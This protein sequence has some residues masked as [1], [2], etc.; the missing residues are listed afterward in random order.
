MAVSVQASG[1]AL[2]AELETRGVAV[3]RGVVTPDAVDDALRHIHLGLARF[4]ATVEE[5][6]DYI[7]NATWFPQLRWDE[8]IVALQEH[9]P[10][11]LRDGE[12]CDPQ[13]VLGF[14][15]EGPEPEI[16]P[17]VDEV[18]P[19]AGGRP[20]RHIAG[21]ALTPAGPREGALHVFPFDADG[22]EVVALE[23]GDVVVM[24]GQ[25]PHSPGPNRRGA[26]R[27]AVYFR[28]LER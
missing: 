1:A 16:V 18:P 7:W 23:P 13:I 9:F 20:Y 14:P 25:L 17:H 12:V 10:P 11:E 6:S 22:P 8:P 28:Y 27:Y 19:W 21:V 2:R 26:L 3:L 24:H 15:C 5:L 4:G